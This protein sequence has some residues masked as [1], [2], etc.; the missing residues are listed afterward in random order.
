MVFI[1]SSSSVHTISIYNQKRSD[2]IIF[3]NLCRGFRFAFC[4]WF[5]FQRNRAVIFKHLEYS[6]T[7]LADRYNA[8]I[9]LQ[10]LVIGGL[11]ALMTKMGG[12][13]AVANALAN[14]AKGPISA[15][16]ISW[17]LGLLLF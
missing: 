1:S 3:R 13:K 6:L 7:S 17:I 16:V 4:G 8:G 10:V 5:D 14:K 9:I 12:T 2:F 11:I 15:Q